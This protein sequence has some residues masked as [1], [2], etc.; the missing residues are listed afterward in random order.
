[1]VIVDRVGGRGKTT[2][3]KILQARHEAQYCPQM[4]SAMDYMAF[5]MAKPSKGYFID[6]P[7]AED[8]K[9]KASL[10]SAIEQIK[11]G[12]L[13]DKRYAYKDAWI[14]PPRILVTANQFPPHK[15]LSLDRWEVYEMSEWG[16]RVWLVRHHK[17]WKDD[18]EDIDE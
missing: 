2:L 3:A 8:Y 17:W 15:A 10:W 14:D 4:D 6:V 13:Y 7:R 1:M 12:Y 18:G 16:G 9:K 11:N 5:A